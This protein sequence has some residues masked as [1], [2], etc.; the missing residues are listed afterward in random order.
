MLISF[1]WTINQSVKMLVLTIIYKE[2][3]K[4]MNASM[5]PSSSLTQK[6]KVQDRYLSKVSKM[7]SVNYLYENMYW[8]ILKILILRLH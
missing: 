6:Q 5:I 1:H 7:Q 2:A 3:I 8:T 4:A